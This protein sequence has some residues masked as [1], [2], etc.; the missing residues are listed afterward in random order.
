MTISKKQSIA[1]GLG[2]VAVAA[3]VGGMAYVSRNP[4][5]RTPRRRNDAR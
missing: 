5:L 4:S 1:A 3:I 2:V